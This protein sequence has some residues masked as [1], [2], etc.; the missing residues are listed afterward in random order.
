[1]ECH[2]L[3][4]R[5]RFVGLGVVDRREDVQA[6]LVGGQHLAGR[7]ERVA[8]P[9]FAEVPDVGLDGVVA[10]AVAHIVEIDADQTQQAIGR[11]AEDLEIAML[12]HVAVVVDPGST[13][14]GVDDAQRLDVAEVCFR[15]LGLGPELGLEIGEQLAGT[16]AFATIARFQ[17]MH[18]ADEVFVA[19]A[20]EFADRAAG[21]LCVRLGADLFDERIVEIDDIGELRPGPF[22]A[23]TELGEEVAHAG[24]AAGDAIGLEQAH[25]RP[26]HAEGIAHDVV[27]R[28]GIADVVLDQPERLAPERLEQAVADESL[29]LLGDDDALHADLLDALHGALDRR[30][31]RLLAAD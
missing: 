19:D 27:E 6:L 31:R 2:L 22:Q 13:D 1:M 9:G 4:G 5:D 14:L 3:G 29:D 26:A 12:G 10:V 8:E 25:L 7:I 28:F 30:L 17:R 24:F 15:L 20:L 18:D 16:P 21:G 23:G 11:I